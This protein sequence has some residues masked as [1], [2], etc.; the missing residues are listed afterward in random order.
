MRSPLV[1]VI[2]PVYNAGAYVKESIQSV[3]SQTYENIEVIIIND[4]S[5]DGSDEIIRS[6]AIQDE[7][8]IYIS[9][10]NN[11]L[12]STLNEGVALAKGEFIARMDADDISYTHRIEKQLDF[13]LE[14]PDC[15]VCFSGVS[16]INHDGTIIGK[17]VRSISESE[18]IVRLFFSSCFYH[19]SVMLRRKVFFSYHYDINYKYAEDY[20]LWSELLKGGVNIK[21]LPMALLKYRVHGGNVSLVKKNEQLETSK[22][23]GFHNFIF[24]FPSLTLDE[25]QCLNDSY[26]YRGRYFSSLRIIFFT[27]LPRATFKKIAILFF[28]LKIFLGKIF[29]SIIQAGQ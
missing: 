19:P 29:L 28:L 7:R 27:I 17:D 25:Y 24:Y 26:F 9:R 8:V 6:F 23:I 2:I 16:V 15:D 1:S 12:I 11:G 18:M 5:F 20:R 10:Q 4:G 14:H 22:K 3:L 13:L 21:T